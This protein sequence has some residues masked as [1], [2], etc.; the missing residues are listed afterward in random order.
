MIDQDNLLEYKKQKIKNELHNRRELQEF[1]TIPP[2]KR[3]LQIKSQLYEIL[4]NY[5]C[6]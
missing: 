5:P 1:L 3:S 2:E 6:F 4:L